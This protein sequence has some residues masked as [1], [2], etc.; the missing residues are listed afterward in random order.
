MRKPTN[1]DQVYRFTIHH[2]NRS[3]GPKGQ[4]SGTDRKYIAEQRRAFIAMGVKCGK[5]E[6]HPGPT[7]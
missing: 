6:P 7:L 5:I 1:P 3:N 4:Y 2:T